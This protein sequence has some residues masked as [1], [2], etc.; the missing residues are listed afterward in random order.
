MNLCKDQY[1]FN[2]K[3]IKERLL[4]LM[5]VWK[6]SE[7]FRGEINKNQTVL[8]SME[9]IFIIFKIKKKPKQLIIYQS[10]IFTQH[11]ITM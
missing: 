5:L 3:K 10:I 9:A 11:I 4:L 7:K 1:Q 2:Q 6:N 8:N